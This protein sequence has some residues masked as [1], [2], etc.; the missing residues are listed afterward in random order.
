MGLDILGFVQSNGSV[1]QFSLTNGGFKGGTSDLELPGRT[2]RMVGTASAT[3]QASQDDA[4]M[5]L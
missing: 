1:A 5:I 3:G 4:G 2:K